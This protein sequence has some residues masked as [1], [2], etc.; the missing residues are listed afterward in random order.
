MPAAA[1][2][3]RLWPT[4]DFA[5]DPA[6]FDPEAAVTAALADRPDLRG[7]REL[8][9][10]LTVETLPEARDL[11][12]A[13]S[14]LLGQSPALPA[15]GLFAMVLQWC[16]LKK[17]SP[18]ADRAELAVRKQQLAELIAERE[19][20]AA[21]E[22]RAAAMTANAQRVKASLAR[23][24]LASWEEKL[25]EA[26]RKAA[27]KQPGAELQVPQLRLEVLKARGELAA[28]VAAWHVARVKLRAAEG[29][30]GWEAMGDRGTP[31]AARA[32][33]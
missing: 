13:A 18:E 11:L 19:G 23:D 10:N 27:A 24:S 21:V 5:I 29:W 4:G 28:E 15:Q 30:L 33:K 2:G 9:Q 22:A 3:D 26:E 16:R 14:P 32:P 6:P 17:A 31:P 7:L 1:A 25:K 12:R 8:Q 20:D